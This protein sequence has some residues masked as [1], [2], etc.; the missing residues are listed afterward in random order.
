MDLQSQMSDIDSEIIEIFVDSENTD[1]ILAAIEPI[2]H[3][4]YY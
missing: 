1:N 4:D 2:I 3:G